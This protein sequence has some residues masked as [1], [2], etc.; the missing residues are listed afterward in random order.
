[1]KTLFKVLAGCAAILIAFN[2]SAQNILT[3]DNNPG[4][5]AVP[6]A[7]FVGA[8]ALQD[9]IA[10]AVNDDIIHVI[11]STNSYGTVTIDKRLNIFGIGLFPDGGSRSTMS[12]I[13]I[14]DAAASGTRISGMVVTTLNLGAGTGALNN[15]LIENGQFRQ[16]LHVSNTTTL[17]AKF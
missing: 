9:A 6:G 3:A 16:I 5:V 4:A 15:L 14:P 13:D 1:M 8:T 11:R 12:Q 2:V 17:K 10:A 7:V